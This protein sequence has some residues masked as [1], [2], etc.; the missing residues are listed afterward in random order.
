MLRTLP[1]A[2]GHLHAATVIEDFWLEMGTVRNNRLQAGTGQASKFR[3]RW[4]DVDFDWGT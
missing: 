3:R 2:S 1:D 4:I